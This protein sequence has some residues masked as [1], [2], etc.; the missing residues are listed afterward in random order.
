VSGGTGRTGLTIVGQVIGGYIGGPWG[1]AIGGTIGSAIGG[2]IW[3][4]Q[5][6][7][8]K[9]EG[10]QIT[11]SAYG[12]PLAKVYGGF[13][14]AGNIIW[15]S[16]IRE[17]ARTEQQGKGGGPEITTYRYYVD[18]AIGICEGPITG[19]RRIWA[20]QKL[21]YDTGSDDIGSIYASYITGAEGLTFYPGDEDQLPD[22]TIEAALGIGNT[23]AFRGLSYVVFEN[24]DL[25][26]YANQTPNLNFE[27]IS[28]GTSPGVRE[29]FAI[30]AFMTPD[31][32]MARVYPVGGD[33]V[34]RSEDGTG[35]MVDAI[36]SAQD[37]T[38]ERNVS[39]GIVPG[40]P[41]NLLTDSTPHMFGSLIVQ[42]TDG[43]FDPIYA[44]VMSPSNVPVLVAQ[45]EFLQG[46]GSSVIADL[47]TTLS[48]GGNFVAAIVGSADGTRIF[49]LYADIADT[50]VGTPTYWVLW[51]FDGTDVIEERRGTIEGTPSFFPAGGSMSG[52]KEGSVAGAQAYYSGMMESDHKHIW[53]TGS[54]ASQVRLSVIGD[55]DV[56]RAVE[57]LT[58]STP[59][60]TFKT[61]SIYADGAVAWVVMGGYLYGFTR[62]ANLSIDVTLADVVSDICE[63]AGLEAAD[64]DVTEL[65]ST[66]VRGYLRT[67]RMSA[68]A[69]IEPLMV[70][71]A[72]D[73]VESDLQIK[74][75]MRHATP[76]VTMEDDDLGAG[77][78]GPAEYLVESER[79]QES[80]LPLS[81]DVSYAA[82]DAEYQI[83]TQSFKRQASETVDVQSIRLA[84]ALEDQE[85]SEIAARM[86]Y[87]LWIARNTRKWTTTVA[88]AEYEPTDVA[89]IE[90]ENA[91]YVVRVI[92][93]TEGGNLIAWD[94]VDVD[95]AAFNP[96]NTATTIPSSGQT[97]T[98]P[99]ITQ[100]IAADLPPLVETH[101]G[102]TG[103]YAAGAGFRTTWPGAQ[104]FRKPLGS[105]VW[106]PEIAL[107]TP[108][109]MGG[110]MDAL[111]AHGFSGPGGFRNYAGYYPDHCN[112]LT[113]GLTYGS[114]AS[115][116]DEEFLNF[117][118]V[119]LVGNEIIAFRDVEDL[120]D[121][122][123]LISCLLRGLGGTEW[124]ASLEPATYDSTSYI[125]PTTGLAVTHDVETVQGHRTGDRFLV[126]DAAT[127]QHFS[128]ESLSARVEGVVRAVTAGATLAQT[129]QSNLDQTYASIVQPH[130][131]HLSAALNAAGS[132]VLDFAPRTFV[133]GEWADGGD[134]W[135]DPT[136][137]EYI[138]EVRNTLADAYYALFV[139]SGTPPF[140]VASSVWA[141]AL[142][143][144]GDVSVRV[145]ATPRQ[146]AGIGSIPFAGNYEL[147]HR[148]YSQRVIC[149]LSP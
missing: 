50:P 71:Y 39:P 26:E 74:F 149:D 109:T 88:F 18:M 66:I 100:A 34:V 33:L 4:E 5:L 119:A 8:P 59:A 141:T 125:D 1:A 103:Y 46:S 47:T 11:S 79:A 135:L 36:V 92:G 78:G 101:F 140:T 90:G 139:V 122:Q 43:E 95:A 30:T 134:V 102:M 147:A 127:V 77:N 52:K 68:R 111:G 42:D 45:Q 137:K 131:T 105:S 144:G 41:A 110:T 51:N 12:G 143:S 55:D 65:E 29:L 56:L 106:A 121:G 80:E 98:L 91:S 32:Q 40:L 67:P 49:G 104:L 64:I 118:N 7:G 112:T 61:S 132:M 130:P 60:P 145:G 123:Y 83:G 113:V 146:M 116:T 62:A 23:P 58:F 44:A 24:F 21:I 76:S 85:A 99:G 72:F 75:V 129:G 54:N 142:G 28:A 20:N 93:K 2:A 138:V 128:T 126:L 53:Y 87:E 117:Q 133:D 35:I 73:A 136:H 16:P 19:I 63:S 69:A 108:A 84:L 37:G 31:T 17:V 38:D 48:D 57:E 124:F 3:P 6:E 14:V 94:G 120:G 86:V 27:V 70:A 97:V 15:A 22:P 81:I 96:T 114:L 115:C 107:L 89:T 82:A 25:S 9:L 10:L 148:H 13:R